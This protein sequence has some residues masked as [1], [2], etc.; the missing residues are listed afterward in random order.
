VKTVVVIQNIRTKAQMVPS[1]KIFDVK[2]GKE[3][4]NFNIDIDDADQTG[5]ISAIEIFKDNKLVS[6]YDQFDPLDWPDEFTFS[7]LLSNTEYV[8]KVIF[9]YD[10]NEGTGVVTISDTYQIKTRIL[11]G[12][13]TEQSPYL[14]QTVEDFMV[15]KDDPEGHFKLL[16]DINFTGLNFDT[17]PV[18]SGYL[19][20]E[21][22]S[23]INISKTIDIEFESNKLALFEY[24][25]G[26]I[27]NLIIENYSANFDG[28]GSIV[29]GSIVNFNYGELKNISFSGEINVNL[30]SGN[31]T[32]GALVG[33]NY[34]KMSYINVFVEFN[35]YASG[36][37]FIGGVAGESINGIFEKTSIIG[38]FSN[39][40]GQ[41]GYPSI[42]GVVGI[43]LGN[44]TKIQDIFTNVNIFID[45]ENHD[46]G[47]A[48]SVVGRLRFGGAVIERVIALGQVRKNP[49]RSSLHIGGIT[50]EIWNGS[51][52]ESVIIR[53]ILTLVDVDNNGFNSLITGSQ[54][55]D[56]DG[57]IIVFNAHHIYSLS[58]QH[59][60]VNSN[61][62]GFDN[63]N[64]ANWFVNTLKLSEETWNF[65]G[66][67]L[68]NGVY[69]TLKY[70]L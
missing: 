38:T 5:D 29:Y 52:N 62:V 34:G 10:L 57:S 3:H 65:T 16:N 64:Q 28:Y 46:Y 25:Y 40:T 15:I 17:M 43:V 4:I 9:V 1:I 66:L 63:L 50:G 53:N 7:G 69:P 35:S 39:K 24:S 54:R 37:S 45:K 32:G 31:F 20:G 47:G 26:T 11:P 49:A 59:N 36:S 13:G 70:L 12:E 21:N 6:V 55:T 68:A 56:G 44:R 33:K 58:N 51:I 14:I 18:F 61:E 19:N 42:G 48:G 22:F 60:V 41:S 8:I 67:D 23:L 2:S 30:V 27:T